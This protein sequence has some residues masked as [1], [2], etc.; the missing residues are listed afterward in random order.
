MGS[1]SNDSVNA[2]LE[3]DEFLKEAV[4]VNEKKN[5]RKELYYRLKRKSSRTLLPLHNYLP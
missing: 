4:A 2:L 3:E 5:T 1:S